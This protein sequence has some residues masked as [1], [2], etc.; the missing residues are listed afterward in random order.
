[1]S[2]LKLFCAVDD[3]WQVF[4]PIWEQQLLAEGSRQR[5]RETQLSMSEIMTIIILFHQSGYRHFKD[6]YL[7]HVCQHLGSAFPKLVSYNRFVE[8]EA[9]ALVP[10]A[11]YLQSRCH[12]KRSRGIAFI[13]ATSLAVCHNRRIPSHR[14]FAHIAAR[15]KTSTGWF[16]GF[17]LHIV[18]NDQG[19]LLAFAITP[20]NVDDRKLVPKLTRHLVG[21]LFGDK[22]YISQK[23]FLQ[24]LERGLQLITTLRKNMKSRLLPLEDRLFLRKRALIET[25]NDQLKNISQLEHSRHRSFTNFLVNLFGALIA[26][27][28]QPKKPALHFQ[29]NDLA[30]ISAI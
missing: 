11:A 2:L 7:R 14:V 19:E 27:T 17:K 26:Y 4:Q 20:G 10:L 24:L 15:G 12:Q 28:H 30:L 9:R 1:M 22:G 16:Y 13:D 3:F 29:E 5:R 23:L 18:I 6:F 25:V 8:L 21:K